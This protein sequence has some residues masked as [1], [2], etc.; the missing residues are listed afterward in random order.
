MPQPIVHYEI[1][2]KDLDKL[3]SFYESLFGWTIT[4]FGP[5]M[6]DYHGID[7]K[8]GAEFGIDGGMTQADDMPGVRIYANVDS[9]DEYAAKVEGLG[10]K[11]VMPP[12]EIPGTRI[13]IGLFLDPENN[14]I[15]VVESM[16]VE[17]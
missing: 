8:Q 12:M 1:A 3:K 10:G 14:A 17:F 11:V 9:A 6:R 5:E 2:A 15:G 16:G 13:K 7:G 4:N